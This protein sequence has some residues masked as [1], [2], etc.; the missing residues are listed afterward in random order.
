MERKKSKNKTFNT[1]KQLWGRWF[2]R[3][4]RIYKSYSLQCSWIKRLYDENFHEWKIIPSYLIKTIFCE[5]YNFH[6]YLE[7]NK[8]GKSLK[9]VTNFYK[10]M[11]T[12][13]AKCFSCSPYHQRFFSSFYGLTQ[14]LKLTI[15]AFL[16]LTFA[17]KNIN[18]VGQIFHENGKT[19]SWNYIKSEY[20]LQSK[21][22]YRWI[23]LIYALPKLWKDRILNCIENSMNLCIFDHHLSKK[24]N[25][26]CLDKL[27]SR[28]RYQTQI[29]EKY[30]KRISKLYYERYFKNFDFDWKSIYLFYGNYRYK[31]KSFSVQNT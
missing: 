5:N 4:W 10:E 22:K 12:N 30:R 6:P 2:E 9:N 25:L 24:N 16:S 21:F 19:K 1:F 26:Y 3:R 7:P 14:T 8:T 20:S 28:E 23:Q 18:F 13:W 15:R 11:M 27:G 29:S 31:I 17:S